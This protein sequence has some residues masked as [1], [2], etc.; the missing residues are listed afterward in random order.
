[1]INLLSY[2]KN[3]NKNPIQIFENIQKSLYEF[4]L[5]KNY[6]QEFNSLIEM[7]FKIIYK[8]SEFSELTDSIRL[9]KFQELLVNKIMQNSKNSNVICRLNYFVFPRPAFFF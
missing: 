7:K 2:S 3:L 5:F 1:M 4:F 9:K 6:S 8:S